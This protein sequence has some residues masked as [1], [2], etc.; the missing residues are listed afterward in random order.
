VTNPIHEFVRYWREFAPQAPP[1]VHPAD[2]SLI[3]PGDFELDL[4]P[5]PVVGDVAGA[6]VI[7]LMLNPGYDPEDHT[8]ERKPTFR[9]SLLRSLHQR[10]DGHQFPFSYL[11]PTFS[12]HPGAGYW[13]GGRPPSPGRKTV[14]KLRRL[15]EKLAQ[16]RG[17]TFDDARM[18]VA[19]RVA[20]LELLPYHSRALRRRDLL[21][22]LPSCQKARMLVEALIRQQRKLI[23]VPRSIAEWGFSGPVE[24]A[25]LVVYPRS[26]GA[27]ASL[28]PTTAGGRAILRHLSQTSSS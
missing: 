20:I 5:I 21:S 6:D 28:G 2:R 4:L 17:T 1:F 25:N 18:I 14:Q 23:V 7:V 26:Q 3:L 13:I 19:N 12:S 27:A 22:V 15:T 10:H 8:W 16:Q 9:E 24:H 11:D